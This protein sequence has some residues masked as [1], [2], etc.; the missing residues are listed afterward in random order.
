MGPKK[1]QGGTKTVE[2]IVV[3]IVAQIVENLPKKV[4]PKN[5]RGGTK[6]KGGWDQKAK[7]WDQNG[8]MWVGGA[9]GGQS[10]RFGQLV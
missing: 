7:T 1:P 4:G 2:N 10:R 3:N 6:R 8:E 5:A 9:W